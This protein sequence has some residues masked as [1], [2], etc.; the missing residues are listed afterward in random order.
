MIKMGRLAFKLVLDFIDTDDILN[1]EATCNSKKKAVRTTAIERLL[2]IEIRIHRF[3]SLNQLY[4][5][6]RFLT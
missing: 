2:N 1:L 5:Y 6:I 4:K 3:E